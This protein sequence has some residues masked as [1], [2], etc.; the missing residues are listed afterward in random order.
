VFAGDVVHEERIL[1]E[2]TSDEPVELTLDLDEQEQMRE[3][4]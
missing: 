2:G 4:L 3:Y 1:V